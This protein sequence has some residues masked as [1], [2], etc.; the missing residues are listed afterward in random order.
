MFGAPRRRP[1][2]AL[3]VSVIALVVALTGTALAGPV[4]QLARTLING[5]SIQPNTIAGNRLKDHTLTGQQINL[6]KL[7]TVSHARLSDVATRANSATNAINARN[8]T[9]V[10]GASAA[11]FFPASKVLRWSFS[12]NKGDQPHP[13]GSLGALT[14]SGTCAADGAKTKAE[15]QLTTSEAGTFASTS[16]G[17]LPAMTTLVSPGDTFNVVSQD[18]AT[19]ADGNSNALAAFTPSGNAA[20]FSTAQTVAVAINTPGADCRFFG[21]L[22]NDA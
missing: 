20:I 16:P 14:F 10:G 13:I 2:A 19:A 18:T 4:G 22:V 7:G 21:F 9:T 11:S 15:V 6:A 5:S 3:V 17:G 12:M 1:S 8:A